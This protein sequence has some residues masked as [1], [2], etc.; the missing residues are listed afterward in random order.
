M[1]DPETVGLT[2]RHIVVR[3]DRYLLGQ[4]ELVHGLQDCQTLPYGLYAN[5]LET[6]GIHEA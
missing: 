6:F 2:W 4:L 5:L 3:V 1:K